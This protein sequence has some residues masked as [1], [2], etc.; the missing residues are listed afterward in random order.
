MLF[1]IFFLARVVDICEM[2]YIL[3]G[4]ALIQKFLKRKLLWPN[5]SVI[6]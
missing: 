1:M 3:F 2:D 4:S 5:G 6:F